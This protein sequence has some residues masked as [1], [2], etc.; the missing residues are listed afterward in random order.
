M[1]HEEHK[2]YNRAEAILKPGLARPTLKDREDLL[3]RLEDLYAE[4]GKTGQQK[5]IAAQR[6][7]LAAGERPALS[8]SSILSVLL[9]SSSKA[10][11]PAKK[12]S[13][14]APCWCGSGKKYKKC[15][16]QANEGSR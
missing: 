5:D 14:N 6:K 16:L 9:G 10:P 7:Q 4:W 12:L 13:R 15:H 1:S 3:E 8:P 11:Q 2:E